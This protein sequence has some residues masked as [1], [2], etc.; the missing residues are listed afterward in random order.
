MIL[1]LIPTPPC[2]SYLYIY[3]CQK[4]YDF[5]LLCTFHIHSSLPS[6]PRDASSSATAPINVIISLDFLK[7]QNIS[8][9]QTCI[10]TGRSNP[11][12][13]L[14]SEQVFFMICDESCRENGGKMRQFNSNRCE[15]SADISMAFIVALTLTNVGM[16]VIMV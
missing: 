5:C 10:F 13:D 14:R 7:A 12:S 3:L 8:D 11:G 4:C 2:L 1:L 15:D 16:A 9:M 6:R